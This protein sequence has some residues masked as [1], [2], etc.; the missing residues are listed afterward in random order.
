M[1][2]FSL[3]RFLDGKHPMLIFDIPCLKGVPTEVPPGLIKQLIQGLSARCVEINLLVARSGRTTIGGEGGGS[4][5][6][7]APLGFCRVR[8]PFSLMMWENWSFWN[9]LS[10]KIAKVSR[11]T[12]HDLHMAG[13]F[14]RHRPRWMPKH[15]PPVAHWS[16][17]EGRR[18]VY[19]AAVPFLAF[20][21]KGWNLIYTRM[22]YLGGWERQPPSQRA[23]V[24]FMKFK[25]G[26]PVSKHVVILSRMVTI[27]TC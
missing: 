13:E 16:T 8:K 27:A 5:F 2:W 20:W 24:A 1:R 9:M 22:I 3:Q 11:K 10:E 12:M 4:N 7:V 25:A 17:S 23:I 21:S 14:L 19:V 26:I 6:Q 15:P 18:F